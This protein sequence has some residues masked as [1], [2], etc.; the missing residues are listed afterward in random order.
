M[1]EPEENK[2]KTQPTN[3]KPQTKPKD[4]L[5]GWVLSKDDEIYLRLLAL[6]LYQKTVL[7][8]PSLLYLIKSQLFLRL[9]FAVPLCQSSWAKKRLSFSRIRFFE[10]LWAHEGFPCLFLLWTD[11]LWG[12]KQFYQYSCMV[13]NHT[14]LQGEL[15]YICLWNGTWTHICSCNN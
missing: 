6:M 13:S 7:K 15:A 2:T 10:V 9:Y 3:E 4:L 14:R 11:I 8:F 12:N 1:K 5:S